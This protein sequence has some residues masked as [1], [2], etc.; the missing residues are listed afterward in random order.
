[1]K[2]IPVKSVFVNCVFPLSIGASLYL[3]TRDPSLRVFH[4]V[5]SIYLGPF[6]NLLRCTFGNGIRS[7]VPTWIL[8]TLPDALWMYAF[9]AAII[10]N[11]SSKATI[12]LLIPFVIGI[13]SEVGQFFKVVPGTFDPVDVFCYLSG[14]LLPIIF[15]CKPKIKPL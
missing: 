6:V 10:L 14:F 4:W 3:T 7:I 13:G 1:M 9:T 15:L 11:W 2:E 5:H 12:Y 8:F